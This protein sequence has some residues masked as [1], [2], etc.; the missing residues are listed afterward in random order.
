MR[1]RTLLSTFCLTLITLAA[2]AQQSSLLWEVSGNGLPKPSYVFGT[3]HLLCPRDFKLSDTLKGTLAATE[4]TYLEIDMDDPALFASMQKMMSLDGGQTIQS[5]LPEADYTYLTRFFKDSLKTDLAQVQTMKPFM[6]TS[7]LYPK[8]LGCAPTSPEMQFVGATLQRKRE[9]RGLE[10]AES[11]FAVLEKGGPKKGAEQLVKVVREYTK[12]KSDF[13]EL[14]AKYRQQNVDEL[15]AQ[16]ENSPEYGELADDLLW[17]R[18]A[19]WI[20]VMA[21]A[22]SEKPTFFAV[23]AGHL[24][25]EKGVLALLRKRGYAVRPIPV[26]F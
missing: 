7:M 9:V 8:M 1:F 17:K 4:Q 21:G 20:P 3:F 26:T 22:M 6:L 14:A 25:G 18:N 15:A 12:S 11:Q 10:T 2:S 24:G 23:G 5:L 16:I 19:A 13:A